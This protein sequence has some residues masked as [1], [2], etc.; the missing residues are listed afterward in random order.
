MKALAAIALAS[1]HPS[2]GTRAP[3]ALHAEIVFPAPEQETCVAGSSGFA[4]LSVFV[5]DEAGAAIPGASV[6]MVP[7]AGSVEAPI[8]AKTNGAGTATLEAGSSGVYAITVV[9][10]GFTPQARALTLRKGCS[11]LARVTLTL[12]PTIVER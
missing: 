2:C 8:V 7:N 10:G 1:V 11:G 9:L 3:L 12:G 5:R 6:Y 4:R